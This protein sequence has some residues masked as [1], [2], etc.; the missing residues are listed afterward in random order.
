MLQRPRFPLIFHEKEFQRRIA[1]GVQ[2]REVLVRQRRVADP[3]PRQS[4]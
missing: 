4:G 3:L 1:T 2:A